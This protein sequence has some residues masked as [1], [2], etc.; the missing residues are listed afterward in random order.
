MPVLRGV[1]SQPICRGESLRF[2]STPSLNVRPVASINHP[3]RMSAELNRSYAENT[4]LKQEARIIPEIIRS[5]VGMLPENCLMILNYRSLRI[6]ASN[7]HKYFSMIT[8]FSVSWA[9]CFLRNADSVFLGRDLGHSESFMRVAVCDKEVS[10]WMA[11]LLQMQ[12]KSSPK[13][14]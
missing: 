13:K 12:R 10:L 6:S 14:T 8:E 2:F 3:H 7:F 1:R 9:H 11:L 4:Y 5:V